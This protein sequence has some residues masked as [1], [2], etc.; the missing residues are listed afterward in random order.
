MSE[1]FRCGNLVRKHIGWLM[2]SNPQ[3]LRPRA[4]ALLAQLRQAADKEPGTVPAV[5]SITIDGIPDRI[6]E[7]RRERA[8]WA[9]HLAM[10]QFAAHQQAKGTSMHVPGRPFGLAVRSL[11]ER[12]AGQGDIH[13]TPVYQ[14]FSALATATTKAAIV[15]HSRGLISQ[16]RSN[17]IGFDYGNMPMIWNG[18]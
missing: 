8:E 7:S 16:L 1:E 13:E 15:A 18:S 11:A 10:T 14:R 12:S 6:T 3:H 9:I 17:D 2:G 5:W 4:T